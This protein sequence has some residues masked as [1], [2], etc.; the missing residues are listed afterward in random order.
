MANI[1]NSITTLFYTLQPFGKQL[2]T[3]LII[4]FFGLILGKLSMIV[5]QKLLHEIEF[6]KLIRKITK[7]RVNYE[8]GISFLAGF[9]F[10]ISSAIIAIHYLGWGNIVFYG[11]IAFVMIV[12]FFAILFEFRD[13]VFNCYAGIYIKINKLIKPGQEIEVEGVSGKISKIRLSHVKIITKDKDVLI[14]PN[15]LI[16]E[17]LKH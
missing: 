14:V 7:K 11:F 13:F 9:L 12:I 5:I 6:N 8:R 15:K 4:V 17:K 16:L 10:Y 2:G 3:A 1:S